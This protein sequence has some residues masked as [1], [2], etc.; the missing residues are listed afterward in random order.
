MTRLEAVDELRQIIKDYDIPIGE[1]YT[2]EAFEQAF[3][4]LYKVYVNE[5]CKNS[6]R[7]YAGRCKKCHRA[8]CIKGQ[9]FPDK[10]F[11]F[12]GYMANCPFCGATYCWN[13]CYW[14]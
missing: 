1:S 6:K 9:I 12:N 2:N 14:R 11:G 13:D 4:A 8:F 7:M 5:D 10:D 3:E